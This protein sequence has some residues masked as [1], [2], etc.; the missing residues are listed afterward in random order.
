[1]HF[2]ATFFALV[3]LVILFAGFIYIKVPG[4]VAGYLDERSSNIRREL[5]EARR[6]R[7]EAQTVLAEYQRKRREAEAEAQAVLETARSEAERITAEAHAAIEDM[8][9][10]RT[11]TAEQKIAQ[12]E[13]QA[14]AD[15]RSVAADVAVAAAAQVLKTRIG[16]AAADTLINEGIQAAKARLN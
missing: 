9:A 3:A 16:G 6:L 13:T 14:I 4:K 12:A 15:V 11:K 2:D 1:M 5:D 8:I 7:E 10:R